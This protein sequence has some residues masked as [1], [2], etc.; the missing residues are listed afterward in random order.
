MV[1]V[2]FF[3]KNMVINSKQNPKIKYFAQLKQ[4][5]YRKESGLYLIEGVKM[6]KEAFD[7]N[8]DVVAVVGLSHLTEQYVGKCDQ[9]IQVTEP[10]LEYLADA[11]S[12]QGIVCYARIQQPK[13]HEPSGVSVCL[14]G[15]Q[16]AGNLGTILRVMV[17][18]GVRDLYLIDT[19]DA[20]SP[21]V[22]RS[23]M[24]GIFGANVHQVS[25][26][27]FA[28]IFQ[29]KQLLIADMG[30]ESVFSAQPNSD[31]CLVLG[32]EAHGVS[33]RFTDLPN[34]KVVAIPMKNG[35]ES[36]NVGVSCAVILYQLLQKTF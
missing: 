36:L 10:V 17:A 19:V 29:T 2:I 7:Y 25:F 27:E 12:P 31:F 16:D 9:V 30:G 24:S 20:Y 13:T 33:K 11:V 6:V 21:K 18:C 1:A 15:V 34:A 28:N 35:L 32:S 14:D 23:S 3:I 4:K 26:D 5:K 22:V 8:A